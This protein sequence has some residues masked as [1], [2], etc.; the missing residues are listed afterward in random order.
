[1]SEQ[2]EGVFDK[3]EDWDGTIILNAHLEAKDDSK[4]EELHK[5]LKNIQTRANSNEEPGCTTYRV[6]RAGRVFAVFEKYTG[7]EAIKQHFV[8]EPFQVLVKSTDDLLVSPPKPLFYK[9]I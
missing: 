8:S 9:E 6:A 5:I 1:M 4:A 3:D 2:F 7:A